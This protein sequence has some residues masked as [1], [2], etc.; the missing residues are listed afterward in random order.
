MNS[1]FSSLFK[2]LQNSASIKLV[3]GAI[4]DM[5]KFSANWVLKGGRGGLSTEV[6]LYCFVDCFGKRWRKTIIS[7]RRWPKNC[8]YWMFFLSQKAIK[9]KTNNFL[10]SFLLWFF[11]FFKEKLLKKAIKEKIIFLS[12]K[13]DK[14]KIIRI[15]VKNYGK[16]YWRFF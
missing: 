1:R 3:F 2:S 7:H 16:N 6:F 9:E 8:Y 11:S 4:I 10:F 5:V 12:Q 13:S 14:K 15:K